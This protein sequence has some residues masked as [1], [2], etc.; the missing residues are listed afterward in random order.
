M[1]AQAA[2]P[3]P[4]RSILAALWHPTREVLQ[5]AAGHV[6]GVAAAHQLPELLARVSTLLS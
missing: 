5:H 6:I 1:S 2:A 3:N 4:N